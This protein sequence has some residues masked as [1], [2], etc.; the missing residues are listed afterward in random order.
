MVLK[1]HSS[2][3]NQNLFPART[4]TDT[5]AQLEKGSTSPREASVSERERDFCNS[6][7]SKWP[8]TN[9]ILK[10]F[11]VQNNVVWFVSRVQFYMKLYVSTLYVMDMY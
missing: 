7:R 9:W 4:K 5:T 11:Y 3:Y 1:V 2:M 10:L 6:F 8:N